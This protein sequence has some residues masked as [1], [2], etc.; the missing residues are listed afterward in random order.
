M[1]LRS[2]SGGGGS[3]PAWRGAPLTWGGAVYGCNAPGE[4][5]Y[6]APRVLDVQ[7]CADPEEVATAL[8]EL[9]LAAAAA[10]PTVGIALAGGETPRRAYAQ[11]AAHRFGDR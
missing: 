3:S 7:V 4:A 5:V 8:A 10:R 11:L 2:P 1:L 6:A 9:L